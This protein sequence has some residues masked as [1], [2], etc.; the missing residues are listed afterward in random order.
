LTI[1]DTNGYQL[2]KPGFL[3]AAALNQHGNVKERPAKA[4]AKES[5]QSS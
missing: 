1:V 2:K 3:S 4:K 5:G